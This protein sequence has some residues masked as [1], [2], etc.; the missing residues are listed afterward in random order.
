MGGQNFA[1]SVSERAEEGLPAT[2]CPDGAWTRR[3]SR[4]PAACL[5]TLKLRG[6]AALRRSFVSVAL[7]SA[8][9]STLCV[10]AHAGHD[11]ATFQVALTILA[12]PPAPRVIQRSIFAAIPGIPPYPISRDQV[13]RSKQSG[14]PII[15]LVTEF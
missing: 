8:A 7:V 3:T 4:W 5:R 1:V 14:A 12:R 11:R 9:A 2:T 10:A 13:L 15:L 6:G